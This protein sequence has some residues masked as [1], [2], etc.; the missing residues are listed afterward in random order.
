MGEYAVWGH[1]V[2][3]RVKINGET[4]FEGTNTEIKKF[5]QGLK[6]PGEYLYYNFYDL[7]GERPIPLSEAIL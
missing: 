1:P 3:H 4:V 2:E 7:F 6:S 5:R